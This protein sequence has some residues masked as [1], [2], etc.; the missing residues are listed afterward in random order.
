MTAVLE[1]ATMTPASAAAA[2]AAFLTV[3]LLAAWATS[4]GPLQRAVDRALGG[5]PLWSVHCSQDRLPPPCP[6]SG[7]VAGP[8][9]LSHAPGCGSPAS[10]SRNRP[11]AACDGPGHDPKD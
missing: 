2:F 5:Y 7:R 11:G 10:S 1:L 6:C 4:Y 9:G 8:A 3:D